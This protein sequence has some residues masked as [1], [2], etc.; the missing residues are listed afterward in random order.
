MLLP[1]S[2][3]DRE[4]Q[5]FEEVAGNTAVRVIDVGSSPGSTNLTVTTATWSGAIATATSL[6]NE[7]RLV[8]VTVHFS[9]APTTSEDLTV[10]LDATDGTAFDTTL[11]RVDPS[12]GSKTDIEFHPDGDLR[13]ESGDEISVAFPNTDGVTFGLRIV[14]Q[15]V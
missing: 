5:K 3:S 14:T 13:F 8:Q 9:A 4:Y 2:R 15:S 12:V 6:A 7:F 1:T 11:L 10:T